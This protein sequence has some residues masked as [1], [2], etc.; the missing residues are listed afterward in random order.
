MTHLYEMIGISKQAHY[1]RV[2]QHIKRTRQE[3][4]LLDKAHSV[5]A[6]H[7]RMGCRKIYSKLKPEGIGRDRFESILLNNGFRLKR[8]RSYYRTTIPGGHRYDNLITGKEISDINQLW[9]SD[10]TYL[11][12]SRKYYLT[13]IQD[14]FSRKV[15][16]WSVSR[17]MRADQT[18]LKALKMAEKRLKSVGAGKLIFHSDRGSQYGSNQVRDFHCQHK[19]RPSMGGKAWENAHAESINGVLKLE[20]LDYL[21]QKLTYPQLKKQVDKV[22]EK[23]NKKR[24]HGSLGY[25]TPE[26]FENF[27][28]K[29]TFDQRPIFTINY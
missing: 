1:K 26:D 19:I 12:Y 25:Q 8:K 6:E 4:E 20:Y 7:V 5:R 10:I 14:V 23:Y 22:I 9:V 3:A 18:V 27:D 2:S 24:P 16:G 15:V 28:R 29:L 11:D 13:L 17:T 21:P